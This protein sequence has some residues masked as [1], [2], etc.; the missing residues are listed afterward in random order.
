MQKK[1]LLTITFVM[2]M[3][4]STSGQRLVGGDLSLVPAYE[5]AGDVWL[6]AD[7]HEINSY[8]SDGMITYLKEVAGWNAVRV[9][10][11]VDPSADNLLATCQ[12]LDYVKRIGKRVKAAGMAFLLDN[13]A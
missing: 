9:R 2:A 11:L 7:G 3:V 13:I 12:D 8:Y 4:C 6:D 1:L 5:Q 10:L